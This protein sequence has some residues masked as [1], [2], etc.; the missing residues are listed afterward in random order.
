M[1]AANFLER[2]AGEDPGRLRELTFYFQSVLSRVN[3]GRVARDR[4]L[5]FLQK[6]SQSSA[7][8]AAVVAEVLGR[9]SATVAVGD[10]ARAIEILA[11]IHA[12]FPETAMPLRV[13]PVEV[14]RGV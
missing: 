3:Q 7:E 2:Y 11:G 14:R 5:N 8:S 13:L 12:A 9:V 4:V 10:R 1:F 6:V